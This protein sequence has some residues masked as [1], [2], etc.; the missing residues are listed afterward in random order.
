MKR[1][2]FLTTI[3]IC[4]VQLLIAQQKNE[5]QISSAFSKLTKNAWVKTDERLGT[6]QMEFKRDSSYTVM[7]TVRPNETITGKFSL[8][9]DLLTFETDSSCEMKAEYTVTFTNETVNFLKKEDQCIG[10]NEITPGIWK[11]LKD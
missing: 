10:R 1:T 5:V 2:I 6:V 9:G 7:L 8:K 4:F 11:S 3:L